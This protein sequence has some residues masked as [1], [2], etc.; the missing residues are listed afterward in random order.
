MA[1]IETAVEAARRYIIKRPRLTRLLDRAN[2]RVLMLI[3][4]A[5]FGKTTLAREWAGDQPNVWYQGTTAT[6]D[7]AALAAGLSEVVSE[8]IPD[9]GSRMIH[10]MRATGTPEEDVDVLAELFAEN[11]ADWPE[12][13]W[14]VFD[15]YQFAM[16]A[17]AP[18]RFIEVLL[19]DAPVRLL[20][21]SRKRPSWASARRL[22]Y[23]EVY[24]LGRTELAMDHDEA[25]S[26]L[27]H[28]KDAPAAGLVA[29][30][31]GWP[32]V[33]G[34]AALTD[35]F[36]L[37]EGSLPDALYDYF[38]EELYQAASLEVQRGLCKL[39]LAPSLSYG[40]PELL[41]GDRVGAILAESLRLG[42]LTSPRPGTID[43][44][45][46]LRT[47]LDSRNRDSAANAS[48]ATNLARHLAARKKWDDAFIL[49]ERFFTEQ[50]FE[51]L[52]EGAL[53]ELLREARFPTLTLWLKLAR[54]RKVDAAVVDFAEAEVAF[55]QAL[56]QE[57]QHFATRAA[58]RFPHGHPLISRAFYTAGSSAHMDYRN[59]E[60]LELFGNARNTALDQACRRDAIWGQIMA[61]VDLDRTDVPDLVVEL[62]SE[63]DGSAISQLRAMST[64]VLIG[65]RTG[66]MRGLLERVE[67]SRHLVGRVEDPLAVS[68]FQTSRAF[69]LAIAGRYQQALEVALQAESYAKAERLLF[70]LPHAKRMKTMASWG[71]RHF[72]RTTGLVDSLERDGARLANVFIQLEARLLRCRLL[73]AQRLFDRAIEGLSN[74][75]HRFPFEGERAEYLGTLAVAEACLGRR[76]RALTLAEEAERTA[77]TVEV[78]VLVP[79]TR[80]IV[81]TLAGADDA[82]SLSI[83]A[84]RTALELTNLDSFVV[85]YRA[86][87][88]IV[89][90]IAAEPALREQLTDVMV[91]ARDTK[92][93]AIHGVEAAPL[94]REV[95]SPREREVLAMIAQGLTNREIAR[96]LF[97]TESTAKVHVRH[98]LDKLGVRTRTEAALRAANTGDA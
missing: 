49:V 82:A 45:P 61:S 6:A 54:S 22:L 73:L 27:A 31:E 63:D 34:L 40:V 93:A 59:E 3:A 28:R 96:A 52:L 72:S 33:I 39:A 8:L 48:L 91:R 11:L 23:G 68:S 25:A 69:L 70:V 85:A 5:G 51:E 47:F 1:G 80:A 44:H 65:I 7:V 57:A 74:P 66:Q 29:L 14:L 77:C 60:A 15:D 58:R 86:C 46:L 95:L 90:H 26:V 87:P 84:F 75:P 71:L 50:I 38:A 83:S 62:L 53:S 88:G 24:E 2:A 32:A 55:R 16:E 9:A 67:A 20:L 41:L 30:A 64:E 18:E 94:G 42:F 13:A 56:S 36:E 4:P 89:S 17:T 35:D 78:L 79:C 12:D 19:R 81:S 98:I 97:I 43:L 21:T 76:V 37:P 10:R 92:L